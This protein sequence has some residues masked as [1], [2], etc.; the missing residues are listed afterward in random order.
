MI[1]AYTIGITL[2][3]EDGV[4][5]GITAIRRDLAQLDAAVADSTARILM[6]RRLAADAGLS[7]PGGHSAQSDSI[8]RRSNSDRQV[9]P[10]TPISTEMQATAQVA[11]PQLP[12]VT[13]SRIPVVAPSSDVSAPTP[14]VVPSQPADSSAPVLPAP[15][16]LIYIPIAPPAVPGP[17]RDPISVTQ[18]V[19][20]A[21]T[22]PAPTPL[23]PKDDTQLP[24][25]VAIARSLTPPTPPS[26]ASPQSPRSESQVPSPPAAK[27][28]PP[29][30]VSGSALAPGS[31]TAVQPAKPVAIVLTAP[32]SSPPSR[33]TSA[34]VPTT[35]PAPPLPAIVAPVAPRATPTPIAVS[36]PVNASRKTL[37]ETDKA[38]VAVKV[39]VPSPADGTSV[40]A[41]PSIPPAPSS[42][43]SVHEP[44]PRPAPTISSAPQPSPSK[45]HRRSSPPK[46]DAPSQPDRL[47]WGTS[48]IA[49]KSIAPA[50]PMRAQAPSIIETPVKPAE[51]RQAEDTG[52]GS[53]DSV[54][55][56]YAEL[57]LDGAVLGR[58]ITRY[59]ER[60]VMRPQV[61]A[62]GFD[63]RMTPSWAGAPIGN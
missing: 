30:L 32:P 47:S 40:A 61:G 14:R 37:P 60:Q 12:P 16:Q 45:P 51:Q 23:P 13:T 31:P 54:R 24:D 56:A 26:T 19:A 52:S 9:T 10:P 58:W 49:Q 53:Q 25:F 4:T 29:W 44:S 11:V 43:A 17:I 42:P 2:A 20:R 8:F 28:L 35:T 48:E 5:D 21:P 41:R 59:L 50:V 63:Q 6:L 62:T 34:A 46:V 18:I 7:A 3:L 55:P 39:V 38:P 57:H 15:P 1:D 22:G 33:V 27:A 36:P